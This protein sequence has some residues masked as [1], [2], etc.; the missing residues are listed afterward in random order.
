MFEVTALAVVNL[1]K[2]GIGFWVLVDSAVY[3]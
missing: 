2:S 1:Y 3:S